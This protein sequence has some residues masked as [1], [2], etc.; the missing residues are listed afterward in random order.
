MERL[1]TPWRMRYVAGETRAEEPGCIFCRKP[2]GDPGHDVENLIL[3]RGDQAFIIMNLYPYNTGHLM[4]IPYRHA[5]DLAEL[6]PETVA[7]LFGLL[8]WVTAAQRRVLSC[9]GINIGLNL[10]EVAGAG[11]AEHLHVHVVPRWTGDANFMPI[12]ANTMVLPELIPVTYAKLRAELELSDLGRSS[13]DVSVPQA[14]AVVFLPG[15]G[16]IAVRRAKDGSLVLPKG[17]IEPGEAAFQTAIREIDEEMG[18]RAAIQGWAATVQFRQDG[19]ERRVAY[20][21]ATGEPGE[22]LGRHLD[23]DTLLLSPEDALEKLTHDVS[24]DVLRAAL[25]NAP[26]IFGAIGASR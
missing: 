24:R 10:G 23:R 3:Y 26:E 22:E 14:G 2:A 13:N 20:F 1:W 19:E 5:S 18:L 25:A 12:L 15:E 21:V 6:A 7:G 8:P 17:H 9:D 11:V 16:K 4:L